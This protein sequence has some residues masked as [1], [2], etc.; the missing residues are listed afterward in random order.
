M[1]HLDGMP[2]P[3]IP[4]DLRFDMGSRLTLGGKL[5]GGTAPVTRAAAEPVTIAGGRDC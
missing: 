1:L 5:A 4:I 3:M 2:A